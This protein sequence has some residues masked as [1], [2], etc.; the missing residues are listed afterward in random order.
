MHTA[1]LAVGFLVAAAAVDTTVTAASE[2]LEAEMLEDIE[3]LKEEHRECAEELEEEIHEAVEE[4]LEEVREAAEEAREETGPRGGA[5]TVQWH[6]LDKRLCTTLQEFSGG[7]WGRSPDSRDRSALMIGGVNYRILPA[8]IRLGSG[9]WI[10]YKGLR[11]GS[12]YTQTI[13]SAT[14]DTSVSKRV[15]TLQV[16]PVC[17][18]GVFE[19]VFTVGQVSFMG[20]LMCGGGTLVAVRNVKPADEVFAGGGGDVPDEDWDGHSE[21]AVAVALQIVGDLHAG[22]WIRAAETLR[23]GIDGQVIAS[24]APGGFVTGSAVS[25]FYTISPGVRLRIQWER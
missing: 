21:A 7:D 4:A 8:D 17:I 25:D 24:Y 19:K 2:R 3:E 23:I 5:F 18:G 11:S 1:L 9:L 13:D 20:G 6:Y 10:G 14:G 22:V 12:Y 15:T 16:I